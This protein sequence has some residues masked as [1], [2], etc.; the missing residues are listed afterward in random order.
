VNQ[1]L[2]AKPAVLSGLQTVPNNT[3]S[4]QETLTVPT[5]F[6][7]AWWLDLVTNGQIESVESREHGKIVG[8]MFFL[9]DNRFGI[10]RSYMPAFTHFLG[11]MVNPGAGAQ[12]TR[13]LKE[14]SITSDLIKKLP[15]FSSFRQ[16]LHRGI[17]DVM[18]FQAAGFESSVQ[19][20]FEIAPDHEKAIWAA[21]HG[22][23][24]NAIRNG[25]KMYKLSSAIDPDAFIDVFQSNL[26]SQGKTENID[27]SIARRL[28]LRCI[29]LGCGKFFVAS[30]EAG[31]AKAAIFV[32]WDERVCYYLLST[33][34]PD[35]TYG[36][37]SAVIWAAIKFA[38][39]NGLVFDFDGVASAG[40]VK[41]FIGF[42]GSVSPRYIVSRASLP[43]RVHL[44]ARR[45]FTKAGNTFC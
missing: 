10:S 41:F 32:V 43:Y 21:M 25:E 13:Y 11:P 6:H 8:R 20:T 36:A 16:K 33:R 23:T 29:E 34:S 17:T 44:E 22:K 7:E 37:T 30:D 27:L 40:A 12:Q 5:I 42:G 18:E 26:R 9:R 39:A 14:A 38:S 35:S 19:F 1:I 3:V 24:R 45:R 2:G 31:N 28:T 4:R 15:K